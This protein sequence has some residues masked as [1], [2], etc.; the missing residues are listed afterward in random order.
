MS[1]VCIGENGIKEYNSAVESI[2]SVIPPTP[3][4][5][6]VEVG[7]VDYLNSLH[8][9]FNAERDV[10]RVFAVGLVALVRGSY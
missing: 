4:E 1:T 6:A 5:R 7:V 8:G 3:E 10:H 9:R 2:G